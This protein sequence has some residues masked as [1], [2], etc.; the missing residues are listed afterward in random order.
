M[1]HEQHTYTAP[2]PSAIHTIV[3]MDADVPIEV[4]SSGDDSMHVSYFESD[5][6]EY[7]I[8]ASGE[9]LYIR[10]KIQLTIGLFMFHKNPDHVKLTM[11]LPVGYDGSLSVTT[12]DGDILVHGVTLSELTA[13]TV[14]GHIVIDKSHIIGSVACKTQDGD[15]T[16]GAITACE[17]SLKTTDGDILLDRPLVSGKLS[18][19]ATDGD[20]KGMLAGRPSDYTFS[21]RTMDGH[22][23]ITSGGNGKT[24]CELK[25]M[26]GNIKV[27]FEDAN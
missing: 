2:N 15:I 7:K 9:T 3:L 24:H 18:C 12:A 13:K 1:T 5:K 21:V 27:S 6:E 23:N 17:V 11:Y 25:T 22:T 16:V 8:E 10:K 4:F 26:D 19:R 14:D 20:I